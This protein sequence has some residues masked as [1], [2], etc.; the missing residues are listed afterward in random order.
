MTE[1]YHGDW[2][3][4]TGDRP[5]VRVED[6]PYHVRYPDAG[7]NPDVKSWGFVEKPVV[8]VTQLWA[9]VVSTSNVTE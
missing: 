7:V 6:D 2:S 3:P 9:A 5:G 1:T 8:D 4:V